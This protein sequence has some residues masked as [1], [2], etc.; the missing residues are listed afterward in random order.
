MTAAVTGSLIA[1]VGVIDVVKEITNLNFN[2]K[3]NYRNFFLGCCLILFGLLSISVVIPWPWLIRLRHR[4]FGFMSTR[5]GKGVFFSFLGALCIHGYGDVRTWIA[6]VAIGAGIF[7]FLLLCIVKDLPYD[8][9]LL[10]EDESTTSA[11]GTSYRPPSDG[12]YEHLEDALVDHVA[13]KVV[14][15]AEQRIRNAAQDGVSQNSNRNVESEDVSYSD[16]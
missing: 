10:Q 9:L 7:Q 13:S 1:T 12:A 16:F 3:D 6:M 11:P 15:K 4:N 2:F 14:E 5:V 8:Q